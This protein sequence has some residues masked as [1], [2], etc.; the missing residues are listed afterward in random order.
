MN[1]NQI[2][3]QNKAS[4][5]AIADDWF[6]ST[7]LPTWGISIP[8]EDQLHL[9]EDL[10]GKRVLDIGCGSGHSLNYCLEQGAKELWG[11]DL[12]TRQLE[13][14]D[15]VL[16]RFPHQLRNQPMEDP[17]GIPGDYFDVVYSV[18]AIG[19]SVDLEAT[20]RN[21]ASY[22][23]P[24][25]IFAFSWD[26]PLMHCVDVVDGQAVFTGCYL[27]EDL[28]SFEK[29]GNPVTLQN[30][31]LSTY[32]NALAKAGF[33]VEQVVEE[34]DLTSLET[35]KALSRSYYTPEKARRFPPSIVIKARK[36]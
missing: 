21:A 25:G 36:L 16:G 22:L 30:R 33:M 29:G 12:S 6:G 13:N 9:L 20:F 23:K 34:T 26:H 10:N 35:P 1:S 4:W 28:F 7:A 2:L 19:W 17:T 18:Y 24:G 3:H 31:K 32:L 14:A 11:L 27:E 8:R 5:D 15:K